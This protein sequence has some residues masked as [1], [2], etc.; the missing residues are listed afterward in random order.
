[1]RAERFGLKIPLLGKRDLNLDKSWIT[2]ILLIRFRQVG[3]KQYMRSEPPRNLWVQPHFSRLSP[4]RPT[5][6]FPN[7][8][9]PQHSQNYFRSMR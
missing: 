3:N 6:P 7:H 5:S 2:L 8:A 9:A 1:M 4:H